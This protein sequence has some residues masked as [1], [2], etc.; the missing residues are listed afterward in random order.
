MKPK[1]PENKHDR[2]VRIAEARTNKIIA[3]LR[4]LG[5]C[6]SPSVYEYSQSDVSKIFHAIE[7]ATT[8]AKRRF[9]KQKSGDKLF[10]LS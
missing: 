4:L 10:R 2:F 5:N 3:M 8:D 9:S 6:S 1:T 7:E